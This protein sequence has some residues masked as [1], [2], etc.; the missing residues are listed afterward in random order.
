MATSSN[1]RYNALTA[2][3]DILYMK[4]PGVGKIGSFALRLLNNWAGAAQWVKVTS[5][6]RIEE[7][8]KSLKPH[9]AKPVVAN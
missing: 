3:E 6:H 8:W 2:C 7:E 5:I 9:N 1:I 4:G